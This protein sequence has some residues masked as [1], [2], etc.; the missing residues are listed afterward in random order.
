MIVKRNKSQIE[1]YAAKVSAFC[2]LS[3]AKEANVS[4]LTG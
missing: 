2:N 4:Y 1:E 3:A